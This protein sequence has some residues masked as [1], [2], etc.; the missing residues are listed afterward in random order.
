MDGVRA[1]ELIATYFGVGW[2]SEQEVL[3]VAIDGGMYDVEIH[4]IDDEWLRFDAYFTMPGVMN[5]TAYEELLIKNFANV[6]VCDEVL[7]FNDVTER[8]GLSRFV[9]LDTLF[10]DNLLTEMDKFIHNMDFWNNQFAGIKNNT[11]MLIV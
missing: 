5:Q 10:M 2:D 3:E 6:Y 8:V 4:L 7:Y 1:L 11:G 9:P